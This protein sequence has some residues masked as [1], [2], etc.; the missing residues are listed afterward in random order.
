MKEGKKPLTDEE[1]KAKLQSMREEEGKEA[2]V[3]YEEVK[4]KKDESVKNLIENAF[5]TQ[6]KA[7]E[8]LEK[9]QEGIKIDQLKHYI[10]L[11]VFLSVWIAFIVY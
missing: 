9:E 8:R 2:R 5:Q 11:A 6:S 3:K 7:N 1:M 4:R 10:V